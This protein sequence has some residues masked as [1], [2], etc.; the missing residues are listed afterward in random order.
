VQ[1]HRSSGQLPYY[2]H[3]CRSLGLE[4]EAKNGLESNDHCACWRS[5][6]ARKSGWELLPSPFPLSS[7]P[8]P[9]P[10]PLRSRPHIAAMG[11]GERLS[12]P[13]GL[14]GARPPN[15][16][17]CSLAFFS[18]RTDRKT[19]FEFQIGVLIYNR[20]Y[21]VQPN[22]VRANLRREKTKFLVKKFPCT[23]D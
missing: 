18:P 9:L 20:T 14:G 11:S 8:L 3:S 10:L 19:T 17:W 5:G 15:G 4:V 13:A 12:F 1:S 7:L 2:W 23:D 22:K 16:F 21:R 6:V